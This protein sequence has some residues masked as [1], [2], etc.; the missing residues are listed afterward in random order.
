MDPINPDINPDINVTRSSTGSEERDMPSVSPQRA[1]TPTAEQLRTFRLQL[2]EQRG[3]RVDQLRGL[4]V[5]PPRPS[6]SAREVTATLKAGARSALREVE[7]ALA[8]MDEG[9]YGRCTGCGEQLAI[10]RLEVLPSR[11]AVPA[12]PASRR[13]RLRDPEPVRR[14]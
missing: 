6:R 13:A 11:R 3:F 7:A 9:S 2:I 4:C 14:G 10:E 12:L 8:R 1:A 5:A